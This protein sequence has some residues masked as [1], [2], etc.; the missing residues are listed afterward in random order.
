MSKF[1]GFSKTLPDFWFDLHFNNNVEKRLSEKI[2][3]KIIFR[4]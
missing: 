3:K 2:T 1:S 4:I